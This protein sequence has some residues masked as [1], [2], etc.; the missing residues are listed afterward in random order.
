MILMMCAALFYLFYFGTDCLNS[1][2]NAKT[3]ALFIKKFILRE[4]WGNMGR[5]LPLS[6]VHGGGVFLNGF[7]MYTLISLSV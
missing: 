2:E 1:K 6:P 7:F 5:A 4:P 3:R